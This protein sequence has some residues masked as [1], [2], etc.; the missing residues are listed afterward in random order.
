MNVAYL[1][2][3]VSQK[4]T[5]FIPLSSKLSLLS[6]FHFDDYQRSEQSQ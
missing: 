3:D 1:Y 6:W 4:I 5:P 2:M